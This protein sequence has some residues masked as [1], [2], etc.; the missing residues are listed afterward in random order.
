MLANLILLIIA[1]LLKKCPEQRPGRNEPLFGIGTNIHLGPG[2]C[3]P[4]NTFSAR[5]GR[6]SGRPRPGTRGLPGPS[7]PG[8]L[9]RSP[10]RPSPSVWGDRAGLGPVDGDRP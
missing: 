4:R 7:G 10:A 3:K 5:T 6:A 9:W 2:P 8:R 1:D